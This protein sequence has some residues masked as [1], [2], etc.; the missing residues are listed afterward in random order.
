MMTQDGC[1]IEPGQLDIITTYVIDPPDMRAVGADHLHMFTYSRVEQLSLHRCANLTAEEGNRFYRP[2]QAARR[3]RGAYQP[4]CACVP[5]LTTTFSPAFRPLMIWTLSRSEMP[6][7]TCRGT[8]LP[9]A[10]TTWTV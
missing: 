7:T 6:V 8:T 2:G 10:S 1:G 4:A 5:S 9:A 3:L